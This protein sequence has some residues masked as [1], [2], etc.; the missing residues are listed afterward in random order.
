MWHL[1]F[2]GCVVSRITYSECFALVLSAR[3][4]YV[5]NFLCKHGFTYV[6]GCLYRENLKAHVMSYLP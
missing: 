6:E 5:G 4:M 1:A 2:M 3:F